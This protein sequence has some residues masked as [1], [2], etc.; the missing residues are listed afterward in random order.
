M[1][2]K[3]LTSIFD[4]LDKLLLRLSIFQAKMYAFPP[5]PSSKIFLKT[6]EHSWTKTMLSRGGRRKL[7]NLS[8]MKK[9][10]RIESVSERTLFD[11]LLSSWMLP[12]SRAKRLN[13]IF[14]FPRWKR[15]VKKH[16]ALNAGKAFNNTKER[17]V[18][19]RE[20]G[21]ACGC[22]LQCFENVSPEERKRILDFFLRAGRLQPAKYSPPCYGG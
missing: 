11:C 8:L 14:I 1:K 16:T 15:N 3:W 18:P 2:S 19:A 13:Y 20:T 10:I 7:F 9:L 21:V 17:Y 22:K 6:T 5:L 12:H 4:E